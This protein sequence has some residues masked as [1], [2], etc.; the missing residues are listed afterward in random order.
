M[1]N[2]SS[3]WGIKPKNNEQQLALESLLNPSIELVILNGLAGSGKTLLALA[4]ALEQTIES[5]MYNKIIYT[6]APV[7]IGNDLG[8]LPGTEEEKMG[9]WCGALIDNL[10]FLVR[11]DKLTQTILDSYISVRAMQYMRGRSFNNKYII[12]D[13]VQNITTNQLKVLLTRTGENSKIIL[14]G[15]STQ[16][17]TKYM[18][19]DKENALNTISNLFLNTNLYKGEFVAYHYLNE[20]VRSRISNWALE[21]L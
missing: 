12:V 4:A 9:A 11:K 19:S 6:R 18:R 17:D 10:E 8:S 5:K 15:D 7:A 3:S 16:V 2:N 13:E 1:S 21:N 14:L 20:G